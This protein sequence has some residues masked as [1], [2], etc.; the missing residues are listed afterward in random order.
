M[1]PSRGYYVNTNGIFKLI[2]LSGIPKLKYTYYTNIGT[3]FCFKA[4]LSLLSS[5]NT[6]DR[7]NFGFG[8]FL[9]KPFPFH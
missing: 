3:V 4:K 9:I 6:I 1:V 8:E 7:V 2:L 5:D